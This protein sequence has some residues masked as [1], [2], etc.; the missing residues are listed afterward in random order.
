M[1]DRLT[2]QIQADNLD[3]FRLQTQLS[4]GLRIFLPSDD[5]SSAQ[6]A[7]ALQQTIERK[8]QSLVN[9]SGAQSSLSTAETALSE[10]ASKLNELSAE[11]LSVAGTVST[12]EE[13]N[14]VID[15][16]DETLF[17][18]TNAANATFTDNFLFAGS[19]SSS[20]PYLKN[21]NDDGTYVEYLGNEQN[22][23]TF[24]D[25]GILFDASIA[26]S[27]VFGGISE[28]VRSSNDLNAQVSRD[29]K[30]SQLNGGL[31]I[32]P[33]G[34]LSLTFVPNSSSLPTVA[35]NVDISH[36]KTIDDLVRV[37]EANLPEGADTRVD[38]SGNG[39]KIETSNGTLA[40]GEVAEGRT[41]LELG[42]RSSSS[43]S[44]QGDDLDA[45]LLKT[46]PLS[47][48]EGIKSRGSLSLAGF[49]ND[50]LIESVVNG[51]SFNNLT[52][53]VVDG[54]TSGAET[55]TYDDTTNT[56]TVTINDGVSS[57]NNV[58]AAINAEGTFLAKADIRDAESVGL[59][60]EGEF[61]AGTYDNGGAGITRGGAD[62]GPDLTSGVVVTNGETEYTIDTSSAETVQ[63]LLNLFNQEEF[64]L[65]ASINPSGDGIDVRSRRSGAD[66]TIGENGGSTATDLGIR[67]YTGESALAD[68]NRGKGVAILDEENQFID[69]TFQIRITD[70]G[71]ESEYTVDTAGLNTVDDLINEISTA[72][73]GNLSASLNSVGNGLTLT[74]TAAAVVG[75][76]STGSVALGADTL[77]FT[78]SSVGTTFD[79]SFSLE[80]I[81]S[82]S[83]G[84]STNVTG[85]VITVDLGGSPSTSDAIAANIEAN[86][87][88]YTVAS[89]GTAPVSSPLAV[90][91]FATTGG[92][93][94][95]GP[96]V[97]SITLSGE[98]AERLGFLEPGQD[99]VSVT[100]NE[101]SSRDT[102]PNEVDS[103]FNTLLRLREA[104]EAGDSVRIGDELNRLDN[105][106]D[107]VILARA[108]I[109]TRINNLGSFEQRIN[110]ES[111]ELQS[112]LSN[113][114]DV[115][116]VEAASDFSAKQVSLQAS[117]QTSA[118]L[119]Q[120]SILDFI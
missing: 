73:G 82:G 119:L 40:I 71:V 69:N 70:S 10:V 62:G 115:D 113:E 105:D 120:L 75:T 28:S 53:E 13:R 46:T 30:L 74:G 25:I 109:G 59:K 84:L 94:S 103:V 32:S 47:D 108:E 78:A 8:D 12:Q 50:L 116:F 49:N 96:G 86:L 3:L 101:I 7:I 24:V 68:F 91:P 81:D 21:D 98:A 14:S 9:L 1:R 112:A 52:L 41:A 107:R 77:Q 79:Q 88:G 95:S 106:L 104:L 42:I 18:L 33:N 58:I 36:A 31:G 2:S 20:A 55:A 100:G 57:A 67:S 29:T 51:A 56:L 38:V 6:R 93:D 76:P 118:S 17:T 43:N 34:A 19:E 15:L 92:V 54:A 89:N 114:I 66:F 64:G 45:I 5:A 61:F 11:T 87:V 97:G 22:S 72:T 80:V 65:V 35:A 102:N 27:E 90:T 16:L 63:D 117:L 99:S 26:G 110:D 4:T 60:G 23:Q 48:L 111:V 83:S 44:I 85:N 39:L 37:I